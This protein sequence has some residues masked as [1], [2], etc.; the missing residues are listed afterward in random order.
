M[1]MNK[2]RFWAA[3]CGVPCLMVLLGLILIFNPVSAAVLASRIVGWVLI[4]FGA[5]R[6]IETAR[7]D[8]PAA[9]NRWIPAAASVLLGIVLVK[10][11]LL[12]AE[13]IFRLLG[14]LLG[15]RSFMEIRMT[16]AE[17]G[18]LRPVPVATLVCGILLVLM[19][20]SAY[21]LVGRIVGIVVLL[22]GV[23]NLLDRFR[24][25]R[26]LEQGKKSDII[27]AE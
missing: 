21:R 5:L 11:P 13:M 9:P 22:I 25:A 7:G 15:F 27:D 12:M 14:I 16:K 6:A 18:K 1:D 17:G 4:A 23:L 26:T 10:W 19:P 20:L 2:V 8:A 3:Q 24:R